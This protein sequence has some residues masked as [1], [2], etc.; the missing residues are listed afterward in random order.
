MPKYLYRASYTAE[1]VGGLL[2]E[3]GSRRVATITNLI[4][5]LG[6]SLES[7]YYAFGED[8]VIAIVEV[9]DEETALAL[10]LS[11][12]ASGA[13]TVK[14]TVLIDPDT[15]DAAAKKSA[16]YRPPGSG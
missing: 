2:K 7:C 8:D 10:S 5:N 14:T 15:I 1:G 6:G 11:V 9:P 13:I 4:N 3:G 16:S 12:S